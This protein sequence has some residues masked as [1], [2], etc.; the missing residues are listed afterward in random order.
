MAKLA[1]AAIEARP[2]AAEATVETVSGRWWVNATAH[3]LVEDGGAPCAS[4]MLKKMQLQVAPLVAAPQERRE[5]EG[6]SAVKHAV[7]A[8]A[9]WLTTMGEAIEEMVVRG[10]GRVKAH[11]GMVSVAAMVARMAV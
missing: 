6:D 8:T 10:K 7:A 3:W 5:D 2:T 4:Y 11:M 9:R 1:V